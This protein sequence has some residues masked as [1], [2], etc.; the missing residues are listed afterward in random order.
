M[1]G[2]LNFDYVVT[3]TNLVSFVVSALNN[4]SPLSGTYDVRTLSGT[5]EFE[6]P[7]WIKADQ[8][9]RVTPTGLVQV[10][11]RL[12]GSRLSVDFGGLHEEAQV[13]V[14]GPADTKAPEAPV[15]LSTPRTRTPSPGAA[16]RDDRGVLGYRVYRNGQQIDDV[17]HAWSERTAGSGDYTVRAY[18][19]A[20]NL[21]PASAVLTR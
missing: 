9:W 8:V 15:G 20:G 10:P 17:P 2:A 11:H 14:V 1:I 12:Q 5:L 6:V 7:S 19:A 18:D 3:A 13:F 4:R 16:P 21:G